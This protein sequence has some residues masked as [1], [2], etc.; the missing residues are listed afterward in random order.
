M[1]TPKNN[2]LIS[3]GQDT[4]QLPN[5]NNTNTGMAVIAYI[6]F[7]VPLLTGDAKKDEFVNFHTK[8]G[9]VLFLLMLALNI[10]NLILPALATITSILSLAA[11]VL[12]IIGV[13][14]AVK[15]R[16]EPLPIIGQFSSMF[17]F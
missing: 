10:I 7:F 9:L 8:Q 5:K 4:S 17:K 2:A 11:F 12:L 3:M 13:M 16:K 1:Q 15:G 14:N 6:V